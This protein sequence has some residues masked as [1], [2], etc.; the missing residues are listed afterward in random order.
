MLDINLVSEAL[1]SIKNLETFYFK[2]FAVVINNE[3]AINF[4]NSIITL[5][6][7]V[8]LRLIL[9]QFGNED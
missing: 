7:L 4:S 1:L 3:D 6:K 5:R 8:N 9:D 2:P